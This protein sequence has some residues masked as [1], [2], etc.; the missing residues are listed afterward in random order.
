MQITISDEANESLNHSLK[1]TVEMNPNGLLVRSLEN[2][3]AK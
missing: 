3:I 1:Q 2:I